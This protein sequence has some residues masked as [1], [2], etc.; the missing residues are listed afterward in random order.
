MGYFWAIETTKGG[1]GFPPDEKEWLIRR[2]LSR[3][4]PES[5]LICRV[6][7]RGD[8]VIQLSPPLIC[9]PEVFD[10]MTSA[11]RSCLEKAWAELSAGVA[12][13]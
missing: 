4:L 12:P 3:R 5:G 10:Q 9:G 13:R 11:I 6:D 2:F 1:E 7:D 8:A